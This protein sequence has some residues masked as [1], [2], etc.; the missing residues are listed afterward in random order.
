MWREPWR[1]VSEEG[2]CEQQQRGLC[3]DGRPVVKEHFFI[4]EGA[5][6]HPRVLLEWS[7]GE[8]GIQDSEAG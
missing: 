8:Q 4:L 2:G 7:N 3:L 5:L 6:G 1:Q